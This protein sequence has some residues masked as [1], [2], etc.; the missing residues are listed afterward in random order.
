MRKKFRLVFAYE[1]AGVYLYFP[2][3]IIFVFRVT[4]IVI[5]DIKQQIKITQVYVVTTWFYSC[6]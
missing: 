2:L 6:I 4:E 5:R 3:F 1:L